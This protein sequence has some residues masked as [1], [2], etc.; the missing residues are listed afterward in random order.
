MK[1][2]RMSRVMVTSFLVSLPFSNVFASDI[3]RSLGEKSPVEDANSNAIGQ[4][5]TSRKE[6]REAQK[7]EQAKKKRPQKQMARQRRDLVRKRAVRGAKK[8]TRGR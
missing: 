2:A 7:E 8:R 6:E 3:D 4:S 1:Q 5:N